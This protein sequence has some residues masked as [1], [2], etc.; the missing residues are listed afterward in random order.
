M[1]SISDL[2]ILLVEPSTT[3]SKYIIQHL[4]DAGVGA[5]KGVSTGNEAL[6]SISIDKPDLVISSMYFADMT[7]IDLVETIREDHDTDSIPFM[8]ISSE[9]SFRMLEPIRQAG[10][11]AM[12]PKP[13]TDEDL[14]RALKSTVHYIDP[15]EL[16]LDLFNVDSLTVLVVDDSRL[17]QK[18]IINVIK[19]MGVDE[20]NIVT[21]LNGKEALEIFEE[22]EFD[23]V[24][25]DLNMPV[26]DGN[27][28]I[29]YIRNES[30]R[31]YVPILM[32]TS[33]SNQARLEHIQQ[34]GVSAICDKPF[35]AANV[36]NLLSNIIDE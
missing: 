26:M 13:F 15:G 34:A 3:Q 2:Y 1:L 27:E 9:Q 32:V 29:E 6:Q 17:S 11:I 24:I 23:L 21:A 25:T 19:Q 10:V 22:T 31:P 14:I 8:L 36:K 4:E 16:E 35:D 12:L 30:A 33:E 7:G 28:M 5:I 18:N 20:D